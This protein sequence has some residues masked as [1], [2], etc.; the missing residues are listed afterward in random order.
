M[1][2]AGVLTPIRVDARTELRSIHET[3]E[4]KLVAVYSDDRPVEPPP[5]LLRVAA[6]ETA[7]DESRLRLLFTWQG[8]ATPHAETAT[9]QARDYELRAAFEAPPEVAHHMVMTARRRA[10]HAFYEVL[11]P[12]RYVYADVTRTGGLLATMEIVVAPGRGIVELRGQQLRAVYE[13][14]CAYHPLDGDRPRLCGLTL[15]SPMRTREFSYSRT[16]YFNVFNY[17]TRLADERPPSVRGCSQAPTS[18]A[19]VLLVLGLLGLRG[20]PRRTRGAGV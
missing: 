5:E 2:A 20:R 12:G 7:G 8:V 14:E 3:L 6:I 4:L 13:V 17:V 15:R 16:G 10:G 9:F 18:G 19:G 1:L 11:L